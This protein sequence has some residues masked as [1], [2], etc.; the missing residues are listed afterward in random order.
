MNIHD[1]RESEKVR[2]SVSW[3][4]LLF[5]VRGERR[6]LSVCMGRGG[7]EGRKEEK[8]GGGG[9]TGKSGMGGGL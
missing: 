8:G 6:L 9:E 1:I 3:M 5:P 7:T 2:T 4:G